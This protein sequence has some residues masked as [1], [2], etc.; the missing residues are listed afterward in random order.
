MEASS[1]Q[2]ETITTF[3]SKVSIWLNLAPDHLDR[4]PDMESYRIAK[5]RIFEPLQPDDWKISRYEEGLSFEKNHMTFSTQSSKADYYLSEGAIACPNGLRVDL[6]ETKLRGLH[7][8]E[9][10][11]AAIATI[12]ALG[13]DWTAPPEAL[14]MDYN[15]PSHRC[16]FIRDLD[17]AE[18]INDSK[19]TNLHSLETALNAFSNPLIL[20]V[21]GKQKGLNFN[22]L[23]GKLAKKIKLC[24]TI[25]EIGEEL[26]T[27]FSS[28]VE[29][30]YSA[31]LEQAVKIAHENAI[32][33]DYVLFSP[34]TSSFDMF[35]SYM[36][37]G[38][39]F[40]NA[41]INL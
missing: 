29:T 35:S 36:E 1:F 3:R 15:P 39:A 12:D 34:G 19:S 31:T 2:L 6:K 26:A 38:E 33:G 24:L 30:R 20:I 21:G 41:V 25:G 9:N 18:Y 8:I 37:R 40:R 23:K 4:Y 13:L 28:E 16:E 17:G 7:N 22:V 10:A 5:E 32:K 11:M 14:M 27:L